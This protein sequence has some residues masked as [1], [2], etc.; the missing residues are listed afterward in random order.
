[1]YV[2]AIADVLEYVASLREWRLADPVGA[3]RAHLCKALG[4]T[5]HPLR[6]IMAANAGVGTGALG[7]YG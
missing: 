2:S 5:I 4:G 1:M 7:D 6:K 3:F